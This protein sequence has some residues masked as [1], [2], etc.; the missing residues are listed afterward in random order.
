LLATAGSTFRQ[1]ILSVGIAVTAFA[2]L[3]TSAAVSSA[4]SP[5]WKVDPKVQAHLDRYGAASFWIVLAGKADLSAAPS[6]KDWGARGTFVVDQLKNEANTTQRGLRTYLHD[7]GIEYRSYWI[8]NAILIYRASAAAVRTLADRPEVAQITPRWYARLVDGTNPAAKDTTPAKPDTPEWNLTNIRAPE[9][10]SAYDDRGAGIVVASLD[11]GVQFDH[12]ALV[13]QYRGN[14]GGGTFNHNYNWFDP[15]HVC[16]NQAPCDT[17][18]HGTHTM[19]TMVGDDGGANQIGVAPEAKWI[20]ADPLPDGGEH[21][22]ALLDAGQWIVA[23]TNLNNQNPK[24]ELRPNIVSNSWGLFGASNTWYQAT[25]DAWVAAG[26]F[27]AWAA[28]NEG[29]RCSSLRNPGSYPESYTMGAYDINNNIASFS[30]RGPS[31]LGVGRKPNIA[32]P[33]VNVRSSIPTNGYGSNSGTSMATPH[34]AATVALIW[35]AVP[36]LIG[37]IPATRRILSS[38]AHPVK[39]TTCGGNKQFNDVWGH[40]RLDAYAAVTKALAQFGG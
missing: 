26:I 28:G 36:S 1:R 18:G 2:M 37:N 32:A 17:F 19:G 39:A 3:I 40:G 15:L 35:S 25:V 6:I 30:S 33:G 31:P 11:T 21:D 38:T 5:S 29:P 23:P 13:N 16:P 10:W 27:P 20:E 22:Q 34:V 12:P 24:P 7:N 8:A 9:V 4:S 14:K